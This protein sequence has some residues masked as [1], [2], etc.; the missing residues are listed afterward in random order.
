MLPFS[1]RLCQLNVMLYSQGGYLHRFVLSSTIRRA[2]LPT[3][4]INNK[5]QRGERKK[6]PSLSH[7]KQTWQHNFFTLHQ[8]LHFADNQAVWQ[9]VCTQPSTVWHIQP[10]SSSSENYFTSNLA[11]VRTIPVTAYRG[12]CSTWTSLKHSLVRN[13]TF[14]PMIMTVLLKRYDLASVC[15]KLFTY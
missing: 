12:L 1:W 8:Q 13:I 15:E 2:S 11:P 9:A 5:P 6:L 4:D 14:F 3:A 7:F 10:L